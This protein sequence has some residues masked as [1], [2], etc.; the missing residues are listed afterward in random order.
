MKFTIVVFYFTIGDFERTLDKNAATGTRRVTVT[1]GETVHY[2]HLSET[3]VR[4]MNHG[5]SVLPV[6][7]GGMGLK[8]ASVRVFLAFVQEVPL[9]SP[10]ACSD[11]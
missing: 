5:L 11:T 3:T 2:G 6:Q 1:D 7:N 10:L 9:P 4:V 8:I